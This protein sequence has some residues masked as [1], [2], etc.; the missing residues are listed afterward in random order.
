MEDNE[1]ILT[2]DQIID[3][4]LN[5][6]SDDEDPKF[7]R[8]CEKNVTSALLDYTR[9]ITAAKQDDPISE[10]KAM[11][12]LEEKSGN[13]IDEVCAANRVYLKIGMKLGA[14]LIFQLLGK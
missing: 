7:V 11:T 5:G 4:V 12:I 6:T 1:C 2:L 9:K 8:I 13:V 3:S 10:D 14:S